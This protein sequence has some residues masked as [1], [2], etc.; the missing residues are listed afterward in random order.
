MVEPISNKVSWGRN[1]VKSSPDFFIIDNFLNPIHFKKFQSSIKSM[2]QP[3]SFLDSISSRD[4][5]L[6][7]GKKNF[8]W[9]QLYFLFRRYIC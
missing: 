4:D 9:I 8:L 6:T 2:T 7:T 5:Y 3:W 1:V